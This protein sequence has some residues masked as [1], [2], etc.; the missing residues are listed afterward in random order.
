MNWEKLDKILPPWAVTVVLAL[1]VNGL[2]CWEYFKKRRANVGLASTSSII[3]MVPRALDR[4][5]NGSERV[6]R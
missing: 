1:I 5:W 2:A 6:S 4:I 3:F